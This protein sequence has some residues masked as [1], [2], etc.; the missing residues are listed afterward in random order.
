MLAQAGPRGF[1][2]TQIKTAPLGHLAFCS[3]SLWPRLYTLHKA[4]GD[5]RLIHF[6]LA[7]PICPQYSFFHIVRW[8]TSLS[9]S[10]IHFSLTLPICPQYSF[11]TLSTDSLRSHSPYM[12]QYSFFTLF[13]DSLQSHCPHMSQ[14]SFFYIVHWFTSVSLSLYAPVLLFSHCSLIHFSL[15]LPI[16]PSTAFSHFLLIHFS[17]TVPICPSTAFS[18]CTLFSSSFFLPSNAI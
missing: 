15:T 3:L 7:L 14:Y 6:S 10:L 9:L 13:T 18:H 1:A 16:C 4:T 12:P 5:T 17:P 2:Y 8:S 11:F